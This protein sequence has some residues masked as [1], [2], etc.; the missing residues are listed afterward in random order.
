MMTSLDDPDLKN[1]VFLSMSELPKVV[2]C[3]TVRNFVIS[4]QEEWLFWDEFPVT[5]VDCSAEL[6]LNTEVLRK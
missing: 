3:Q 5:E 4:S 6:N 1:I 2:H